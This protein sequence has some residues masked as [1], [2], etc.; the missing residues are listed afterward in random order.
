MKFIA[1]GNW[2]LGLLV[3]VVALTFS[4]PAAF[5]A[6]PP[7]PGQASITQGRDVALCR[8]NNTE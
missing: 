3:G 7:S 4:S 8:H 6:P 1:I 2:P 5:A